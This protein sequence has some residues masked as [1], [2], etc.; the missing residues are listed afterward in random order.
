[1]P[2]AEAKADETLEARLEAAP[3]A[4]EAADAAAEV[5]EAT[6]EEA[7]PAAEEAAPAADEAAL[8]TADE[9]AP[10]ADEAPGAL[11]MTMGA[12]ASAQVFWTAVMVV[13]WSAAEQAPWTQGWTLER[14]SEP[15]WQWH[16]KSVMEEHP[17][18]PR[19]GMKQDS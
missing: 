8:A 2:V 5:A 10:A 14:S 17:S 13:A 1:M 6:A 18:E 4:L 11:G 7:A 3:A 16:L 19:A 12:P 9:A 15:F